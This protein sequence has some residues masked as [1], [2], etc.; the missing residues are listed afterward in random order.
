[1]ALVALSWS[2]SAQGQ[3]SIDALNQPSAPMRGRGPFPGSDKPG[4]SAGLPVR[5]E[6]QIPTGELR[7]DGTTLVDFLITNVG[8]K[9][10]MLPASVRQ[11]ASFDQGM[12]RT[13]V[14]TLWVSS[15]AI[16]D[17]YLIDQT[18]SRPVKL[19]MVGTS[20][21]LYGNSSDLRTFHV[22]ALDETIR[23]HAS[24]GAPFHPGLASL[25]GHAELLRVAQG[26]S[27]LVG[28]SDG[29]NVMKALLPVTA[30]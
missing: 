21:V 17:M 20:A 4:H 12:E 29:E 7:P 10:I 1:M 22:L 6:L 8:T 25:T 3:V 13:D 24:S 27:D 26:R 19:E 15:D 9:P 16:K 2:G 14:L 30:R 23:V 28:T 11:N 5:V 18:T